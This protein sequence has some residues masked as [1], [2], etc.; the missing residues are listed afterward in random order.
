MQQP[1]QI[2]FE[3]LA[4][5]DLVEQAVR[6]H[7]AHLEHFAGDIVS[8]RVVVDQQ[9]KHQQ[10]GRPF[11]VR[12]GLTLPG[13]HELEAQRVQNEDLRVALRDAF[14]DMK[15]QLEDLVRRRRGQQKRH[16]TAD[17]GAATESDS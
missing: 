6:R 1:L 5:S 2:T 16:E 8:C 4:R 9:P 15:R 11:G 14:D 17:P 13:R 7:C 10:Q 12:I 3:G